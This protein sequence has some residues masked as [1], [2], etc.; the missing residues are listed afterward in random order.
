MGMFLLAENQMKSKEEISWRTENEK[1]G[2][3]S[4]KDNFIL[5][6]ESLGCRVFENLY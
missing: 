2:E 4:E 3:Y 5:A 6:K 1:G